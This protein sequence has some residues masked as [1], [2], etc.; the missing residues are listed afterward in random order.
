MKKITLILLTNLLFITASF[1]QVT[2]APD[3]Y[4]FYFK[5]KK[6]TAYSVDKPNEF[7]SAK[8]ID[9]RERYGIEITEQDFPVNSDYVKQLKSLG[10]KI[11]NVS[12]WL[13]FAV[14]YTKN[15]SLVEKASKLPF[16]VEKNFKKDTLKKKTPATNNSKIKIKI[17]KERL[18]NVYRYGKG[19]N[20]IKMLN[21]HYLHNKGY[22]GEGM[23]IAIL[24]NGFYHVDKLPAFDSIRANKQILGWHDFVEGDKKV[25][26]KGTHGMMVL[27]TIGANI[28]GK[29]VGTAPKANFWLLRTENDASEYIIEEYNWICGVEFADSVGADIIHSSL[30]YF[31]FDDST[32]NHSYEDMDGNT[33]IASIASDIAAGKGMLINTSAGNS[34][35]SNHKHISTPADADSCLAIGATWRSGRAAGFT[36]R[37]PAFDNRVKPNVSAKGVFTT[38]QRTDGKLGK[39]MGTSLSGPV[40]AGMTACLWQAFPELNNMELIDLIQKSANKY[41]KPTV[42]L[43]YGVP[44]FRKAYFIQKE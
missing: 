28:P 22:R 42:K 40:I 6:G 18:K 2:V 43:G 25:W 41:S 8:A 37:G 17:K 7:L 16:V 24:D 12:K 29:F 13:N 23:T 34:G 32:Q 20:Q 26:D 1:S 4:C 27:S 9:R 30:G 19:R 39:S 15:K 11:V 35:L 44:D 36:S 21:G 5:D 33:T 31:H 38:I 3:Y 10:L 14:V